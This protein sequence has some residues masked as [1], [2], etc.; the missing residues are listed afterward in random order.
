MIKSFCK[1]LGI[2]KSS[3]YLW[4]KEKHTDLINILE[5]SFRSK[6]EV[7]K[8][9]NQN[10]D[11]KELAPIDEKLAFI[12]NISKKNLYNWKK[13][14]PLL[15]VL[16]NQ[17]FFN[18]INCSI[19]EYI[20]KKNKE[21]YFNFIVAK[22]EDDFF[23]N[24]FDFDLLNSMFHVINFNYKK[25]CELSEF[26]TYKL[27]IIFSLFSLI[28]GET[29]STF[30]QKKRNVIS[31]FINLDRKERFS[32]DEILKLVEVM[33][34]D[35]E[36]TNNLIGDVFDG[37]LIDIL[38]KHIKSMSYSEIHFLILGICFNKSDNMYRQYNHFFK[39]F[40]TS[41]KLLFTDKIISSI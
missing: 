24:T 26:E 40:N 11:N 29:D 38:K 21:V 15:F 9:I 14:K 13:K 41:K 12:L 37:Y 18:N 2:K 25:F 27:D 22:D 6:E 20:D 28:H 35:M 10:I 5:S 3:Y 23:I 32:L 7:E 34:V 17:I 33:F 30:Y 1:I 39:K 31:C 16:M 8:W 19:D 4:K 36:A